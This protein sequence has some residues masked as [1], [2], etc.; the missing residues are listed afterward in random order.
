MNADVSPIP[1]P[2][3][4]IV[5]RDVQPA[6]WLPLELGVCPVC[7][8]SMAVCSR[9]HVVPKGLRGDDVPEN[10]V[11]ICGDGTRGCHGVLTHH[12]RGTHGLDHATV[13]K[14]FVA[15][16]ETLQPTIEYVTRTKYDGWL[17]AYYLGRE[18]LEAGGA[19]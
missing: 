1:R 9:A 14:A 15:Y 11:W 10:V 18:A 19:A 3:R 16:V 5:D 17:R 6:D 13:S 2:S 4:R 7:G 12:G 8:G